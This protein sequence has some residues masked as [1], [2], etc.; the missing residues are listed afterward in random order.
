ML[1]G[2]FD[3]G[4]LVQHRRRVVVECM[5]CRTIRIAFQIVPTAAPTTRLASPI[6]GA[7]RCAIHDIPVQ[8]TMMSDQQW[9]LTAG[10]SVVQMAAEEELSHRQ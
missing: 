8:S 1:C 2:W 5:Q 7:A 6:G 3:E 4:D 9:R 10:R